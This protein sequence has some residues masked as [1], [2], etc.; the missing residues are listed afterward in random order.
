VVLATTEGLVT[1]D[2][3]GAVE[4]VA[5]SGPASALAVRGTELFAID[6]SGGHR[7]R[8]YGLE[9]DHVVPRET[10]VAEDWPRDAFALVATGAGLVTGPIDLDLTPGSFTGPGRDEVAV[11]S[12]RA[13]LTVLDAA[14]GEVRFSARLD[15]EIAQLTAAD[16]DGDGVDELA[17]AVGGDLLVLGAGDRAS[18]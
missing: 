8:R 15:D 1:V 3:L 6:A 4:T 17:V 10:A 11:R 13:D 2:R 9:G 18:D 5:G 12:G 7:L 16:L 14:T